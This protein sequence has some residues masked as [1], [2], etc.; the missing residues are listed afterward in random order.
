MGKTVAG[1]VAKA[2]SLNDVRYYTEALNFY[3]EVMYIDPRR[4]T[5][6]I[7]RDSRSV[8]IDYNGFS[9]NNLAM[10]YAFD[11]TSE[12]LLLVRCVEMCGCPASDPLNSIS[13]DSLGMVN[14]LLGLVQSGVGT[15]AS[16]LPSRD[17]AIRYLEGVDD[18]VFPLLGKPAAGGNGRGVKKL[19]DREK[20]LK[21]CRSHFTEDDDALVLETFL[22]YRNA[23]RV[24]VIDGVPVEAYETV[25]TEGHIAG[26]PGHDGSAVAVDDGVKRQLFDRVAGC[27]PDRFAIGVYRVG[28]A[29]TGAGGI[30]VTAVTRALGLDEPDR[31]GVF[32]LPR[33]V[34][35]AISKRA[36][37][38]ESAEREQRADHV[39]TFLGDTNPGDS[40]QEKLE[41]RGRGNLLK[42]RG[43]DYSFQKFRPLLAASDFT[44]ANLEAAVTDR[45]ESAL[46]E[47]K[48]YLDY[49]D[50]AGVSELLPSLGINAV[51]LANNHAMDFG[52]D[53]LAD[54][55]DVM[56]AA[57]VGHIGAGQS[58]ADAAA[59]LHHHATIGNRPLHVVIAS[60]FEYQE[61][62]MTWEYY[63]GPE[64]AGVNSWSRE[65]AG[66]QIAALRRKFTDAFIIAFPHWGNNYQ[67]VNK[68][69]QRL[70]RVLID[71]GADL[72]VG[73]GAHVLQEI[74]RYKGKW[75]VYGLGNFVFNS[76][77]RYARS[78]VLPFGL[79]GRLNIRSSRGEPAM[80][81]RLYPIQSDN[82]KT[83]YLPNFVREDEFQDLVNFYVL[84]ENNNEGERGAVTSGKDEFGYYFSLDICTGFHR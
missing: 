69:Q 65:Q 67:Y 42:E 11:G 5:Y 15:S 21:F 7:D 24:Y 33:R 76:P 51:S 84:T 74:G 52:P 14:D 32:N 17:A 16:I 56:D 2:W 48:R 13:R 58:A 80:E 44:L 1:I 34:H 41:A 46:S 12:T 45:R 55:I 43:Y 81:L 20:A 30:H 35:E 66:E 78:E 28:V 63:A 82:R 31:T 22:D 25:S 83:D 53:G 77:G 49:A 68:R 54:T 3:D 57:G 27:L 79:I 29:V 26:D 70:A 6:R 40:Y 62:H 18:T 39:I 8:A 71:S 73:H 10:L 59:A 61:N 19:E 38:P 36:R 64:S 9:L 37:K 47:I 23:Y 4:V 75:V 50:A 60:G 72:V